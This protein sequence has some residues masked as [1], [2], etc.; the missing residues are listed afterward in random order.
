M[1]FVFTILLLIFS[2]SVEAQYKKFKKSKITDGKNTY[3]GYIGINRAYY[4]KTDLRVSGPNYDLTL[5]D[6]LA[7][8]QPAPLKY[9]N[10]F[11]KNPT[12]S[13]QISARIGRYIKNNVCLSVGYDKF[14]YNLENRARVFLVG[15]VG[16]TADSINYGKFNGAEHIVDTA[17]FN[18]QNC[19][20]NYLRLELDWTTPWYRSKK[21]N[22]MNFS[23]DFG[24]GFGPVISKNTFLFAGKKDIE[25]V[26]VS[27]IGGSL[28][29]GNRLEFYNRIFFQLNL[30]T[31]FINQ[32][33]VRTRTLDN[34]SYSSQNFGFATVN[35]AIGMF[36]Y[37][38]SLNGCDTCPEW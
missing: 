7:S 19:G 28:N 26:S 34:S 32:T 35:F 36:L 8:D 31:G 12:I 2:F 9:Q 16:A 38:R 3:I 5:K 10:Y 14:S 1:R 24:I 25:T 29:I 37:G 27:G 30:S 4:T 22:N 18:Y 11:T 17:V 33:R 21:K 13:P 15:V 6:A 20:M 23:T